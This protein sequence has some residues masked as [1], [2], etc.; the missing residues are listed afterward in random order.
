MKTFTILNIANLCD[1]DTEFVRRVIENREIRPLPTYGIYK[2]RLYNIHQL[3][4][5]RKE[6]EQ[7]ARTE[8]Y[9]DLKK[10]EIYTLKLSEL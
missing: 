2:S 5:I 3:E 4:L 7:L 8:I 1:C 6:L 9:I 10:E